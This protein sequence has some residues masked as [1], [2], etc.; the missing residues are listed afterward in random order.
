M[1]QLIKTTMLGFLIYSIPQSNVAAYQ[2]EKEGLETATEIEVACSKIDPSIDNGGI[3]RSPTIYPIVFYD[4]MT[5][6]LL[7]ENLGYNSELQILQPTTD[8]ILYSTSIQN[9]EAE[10]QLPTDLHGQYVLRIICGNYYF[11]GVLN[12]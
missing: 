12:L 7:L 10:V 9:E 11:S 6:C 4:N 8:S 5:H 3:H 1:K 2:G